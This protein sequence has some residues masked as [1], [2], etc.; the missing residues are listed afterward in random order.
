M[1]Q[2]NSSNASDTYETQLYAKRWL[3]MVG[4]GVE[5]L[6]YT[7]LLLYFGVNND[8]FSEY[9]DLPYALIDWLLVIAK[10]ANWVFAVGLAILVIF[11]K[12]GFRKLA[13]GSSSLLVIGCICQFI[14][15]TYP[16]LNGILFVGNFL[17]GTTGGFL[18][19]VPTSFAVHWFPDNEIGSAMSIRVASARLGFL[20]AFFIPSHFLTPCCDVNNQCSPNIT[21]KLHIAQCKQDWIFQEKLKLLTYTGAILAIAVILLLFFVILAMDQPPKPPTIA[22]ARFRL[23]S[24]PSKSDVRRKA[25]EFFTNVKTVFTDLTFVLLVVIAA[26]LYAYSL[27][28]SIFLCEV[29]RPIFQSAFTISQADA[30]CSYLIIGFELAAVCNAIAT[31]QIVDRMKNYVLLIQIGLSLSVISS[32]GLILSYCFSNLVGIFITNITLGASNGLLFIPLFELS[33]QHTYPLKP[34]FV[35]SC[36]TVGYVPGTI[37]VIELGRITLNLSN[38]L[39]LLI[40]QTG[41]LVVALLLTVLLKPKYRRLEAEKQ[42]DSESSASDSRHLLSHSDDGDKDQQRME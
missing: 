38:G 36:L 34:D 14:A 10:L 29:V 2:S 41:Y 4:I 15:Y 11:C 7:L 13:I 27:Y 1:S 35:V 5:M 21:E 17:V 30:T 42:V 26:L 24:D 40:F 20:L 9:F 28:Q 25:N 8:V 33:T 37:F 23:I 6:M 39:G 12:I 18:L 3:L 31:G 16:N 32:I 19:V 22:L